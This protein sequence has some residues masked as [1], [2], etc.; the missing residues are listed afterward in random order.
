MARF[1]VVLMAVAMCSSAGAGVILNIPSAIVPPPVAPYDF[2]LDLG[3]SVSAPT[4]SQA[5]TGYDLYLQLAGGTGLSITGVGTGSNRPAN[6][7]FGSDPSYNGQSA[8]PLYY[9]GDFL[10]SGSGTITAGS[11]L[12]R[13]KAR[14]QPGATGTYHLDAVANAPSGPTSQFYD[15]NL[16]PITDMTFQGGTISVALL[17][18]AN[19][20]GKVDIN[21]LTIVLTN[22]NQTSGG[23]GWAMGDSNYDGKVDIND[24][25]IVLTHYNQSLGESAPGVAAVPE[26]SG[27]A[28]LAIGAIGMFA[29][30]WRRRG[31]AA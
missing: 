15:G 6:C 25:T 18:D 9:F 26:P 14:L 17:G 5:L 19:L 3:F 16:A 11:A 4:V 1:C 23:N 12:L 20:D 22:Y 2:S 8:A 27:A 10:A 13:V 24:L 31:S 7:V 21:D 28:L 30:V 29:F